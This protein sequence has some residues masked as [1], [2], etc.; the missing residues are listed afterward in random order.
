MRARQPDTEGFVER[1]GVRIFYE[2]HGRGAPTLLLLPTFSV[3]HSR[4]WKMQIPYLARHYRVVT[5]DGRGNGRSDR[6]VGAAAYAPSE[7]VADTLAVMDATATER[8]V[9]VAASMGVKRTLLLTVDHPSRIDA[10]VF[11][12]SMTPFSEVIPAEVMQAFADGDYLKFLDLFMAAA[13][14]D[15]H[16]TKAIEDG[17]EWGRETALETLSDAYLGDMSEFGD[18]ASFRSLCGRVTCP[19][20]VIQG[21]EDLLTPLAHGTGLA[22]A[23][24]EAATLVVFE[25]G[26]HRPDVRDP[27]KTSLLLRQFIDSVS[28]RRPPARSWVRATSRPKRALFLSSP[29]GLGHAQRDVAIAR[30]LRV[31]HPELGIDWLA[32][33]PVTRVLEIEGE[34]VH[35]A[36]RWLVNESA[37]MEGE[38]AEHD[39]HCFQAWRRMDEILAANFMVLHDVLEDD[40]YDLVIGDEAWE[41]DHFLHENPELKRASFVWLTDFVGWL[42]MPDGGEREDALAAD[43]NAEMIEHIDRFPG[44]RDRALFVG[45]P[46]DIVPD[47]FGPGLPLIGEWTESHYDFAGYVTGFDPTRLPPPPALRAELGYAPEERVCIVTVGGSGVG[48]ALL[49][50]VIEA[51]PLVKRAVSD[52]RMVVVAGPRLDPATL[53]GRGHEGLEIRSFVPHLYRHLAACDVAVVQGGLT[54]TMEL[55]ASRRPFL[56]FPLAHHFEQNFHVR[57]RLERYRSGRRMDFRSTDP[58]GLS[59]AIVEELERDVDYLPVE[60]DGAHRAAALI[61]ELI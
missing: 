42:P 8:A 50:K 30:E 16:S 22:E 1:G 33:D 29:I 4:I 56:Y 48:G 27:V 26:G 51:F 36:S 11:L 35:P 54:T 61:A 14:S 12:G 53:P 5:F 43:Y 46:D 55:T 28:D 44:V 23:I 3:V 15:P 59:A 13:F 10:A 47:R 45:N 39:L 60:T 19:V 21:S 17:V 25:G 58:D 31:M 57:H 6:P 18:V 52:L 37:H 49:R 38:S 40:H 20:L 32:Q 7:F 2:V 9:A 41:T 24:G 34:T